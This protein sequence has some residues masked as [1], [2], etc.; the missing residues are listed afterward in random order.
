VNAIQITDPDTIYGPLSDLEAQG[1]VNLLVSN[2]FAEVD[3]VMLNNAAP[4]FNDERMRRAVAHG[5][6]RDAYVELTGGTGERA[7]QPFNE[8]DMG[9]VDDPGF[10]QYD[11]EEARRL[12][13]EYESAG[14]PSGFTL[15]VVPEPAALGRA[16][17]IQRQLK[18]VGIDVKLRTG[19]QATLINEALSGKYQATMWKQHG[20][21]DADDGYIWW[22]SPPNPTNLARVDDPVIDKALEDGRVETDPATRQQIYQTIAKT[23][24]EKVYNVWLMRTALGVG[25]S[26]KVHGVLAVSLPDGSKQY[27]GLHVGHVTHG[28]WISN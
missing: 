4:P 19:D 10:P 26:P 20:G 27:P 6:D 18:D 7:D 1:A 13:A 16:E 8:G 17:I 22:H 3:Y 2:A 12:V 24:G 23:F 9:Y 11:P 5:L 21:G 28:M 15:G 25:L 14:K